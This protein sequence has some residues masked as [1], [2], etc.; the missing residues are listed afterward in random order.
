MFGG[1]PRDAEPPEAIPAPAPE[2]SSLPPPPP[3]PRAAAAAPSQAKP[4]GKGKAAASSSSFRK[5]QQQRGRP[6]PTI[7]PWD[8]SQYR[9]IPAGLNGM[10]TTREPWSKD[11]A[12]YAAKFVGGHMTIDGPKRSGMLDALEKI[13]G[14]TQQA[15]GDTTELKYKELLWNPR[16]LRHTPWHLRGCRPMTPVPWMED[17]SDYCQ[18]YFDHGLL[19]PPHARGVYSEPQKAMLEYGGLGRI[20]L[21]DPREKGWDS[22]VMKC[23][24]SHGWRLP[25]AVTPRPPRIAPHALHPRVSPAADPHPH[26]HPRP[27]PHRTTSRPHR[28]TSRPHLAGMCHT[29]SRASNRLQTSHGQRIKPSTARMT[30]R[31]SWRT[32]LRRQWSRTNRHSAR[33]LS[34]TCQ[35][36][37]IPALAPLR[38]SSL[39]APSSPCPHACPRTRSSHA[40]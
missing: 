18:K 20:T 14:K 9:T 19:E 17:A 27:R 40:S 31:A 39:V 38:P 36:S 1:A 12:D 2:Q 3:E 37:F 28:T 24:P 25:R 30:I 34:H 13:R 6:R 23:V 4:K 8:G 21:T 22:S 33:S 26:P 10:R 11:A 5:Q 16:T 32:S 29:C 35:R 7:P 15:I